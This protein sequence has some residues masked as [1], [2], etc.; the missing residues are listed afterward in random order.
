MCGAFNCNA[1]DKIRALAPLFWR[2]VGVRSIKILLKNR[3]KQNPSGENPL[4]AG[5]ILWCR[6]NFMP[7]KNP[8]NPGNRI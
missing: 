3:G 4:K 6:K 1:E 2:V 5:K 8:H 7:L